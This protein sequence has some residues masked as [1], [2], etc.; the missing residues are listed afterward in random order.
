MRR[1]IYG[2]I[3]VSLILTSILSQTFNIPKTKAESKTWIVD[4][5]GPAD[6]HTIADAVDVADEGDT[7]LVAAGKYY[8]HDIYIGKNHI[9]ILGEDPDNTI[10]EARPGPGCVFYVYGDGVT[11]SGFTIQRNP[12]DYWKSVVGIHIYYADNCII[13]NNKIKGNGYGILL[14]A[15]KNT[16]ITGNYIENNGVAFAL[17]FRPDDSGNIFYNNIVSSNIYV[18]TF[19]QS[20]QGGSSN[21]I[22][23]HNNFLNYSKVVWLNTKGSTVLWDNGYPSGGNYWSNYA[24][25]DVDGDGIGDTP[26]VID[27]N[28]KDRYPLMRP[29][30]ATTANRYNVLH[31]SVFKQNELQKIIDSVGASGLFSITQVSVEDFNKG[32]PSDLSVYDALVFG[33]NDWGEVA[34]NRSRKY[35]RLA[36]LQN[37]VSNGGGI[38][39]THDTLEQWW[40]Y[41]SQIE[42]P[43][44]VDNYDISDK[45][46]ERVWYSSIKIVEDHAIL[47]HPYEIGNVGDTI[48]VQYTHTNGGRVKTAKTIIKSY[49]GKFESQATAANDF[50]LTINEYGKGRVAI[51]EIG[52]S[53]IREDKPTI[54]N[55]P[56][57][58]ESKILVNTLY[59]VSS[60]HVVP[61]SGYVLHVQSY[62][63]TGVEISYSGD[64]SGS[65]TTNFDIGPKEAPFTVTLKAPLIHGD[66]KFSH[67][68]L[69]G[70][71]MGQSNTL[72]VKVDDEKMERTAVAVYSKEVIKYTLHVKSEP[73]TGVSISYS[74]DYSGTGT[75]NFDVGPKEARFRVILT[76]PSMFQNYK[77]VYWHIP[78]LRLITVENPF[79]CYHLKA[80]TSFNELTVIAVYSKDTSVIDLKTVPIDYTGVITLT[81]RG[82]EEYAGVQELKFTV[83][84]KLSNLIAWF[85]ISRWDWHPDKPFSAPKEYPN[86]DFNIRISNSQGKEYS[87]KMNTSRG[88]DMIWIPIP[89]PLQ[90]TWTIKIIAF[91]EDSVSTKC[92][93]HLNI[94]EDKSSIVKPLTVIK[95]NTGKAEEKFGCSLWIEAHSKHE[96]VNPLMPSHKEPLAYFIS[97]TLHSDLGLEKN[98][99][100]ILVLGFDDVLGKMCDEQVLCIDRGKSEGYEEIVAVT[101]P[102]VQFAAKWSFKIVKILSQIVEY[103]A[104][105]IE[106]LED[107]HGLYVSEVFKPIIKEA[108]TFYEKLDENK[109]DLINFDIPASLKGWTVSDS[110][111]RFLTYCNLSLAPASD[112]KIFTCLALSHK[113]GEYYYVKPELL[114]FKI[115]GTSL[116]TA[117]YGNFESK[118]G[119]NMKV[120][121]KDILINES[122][123]LMNEQSSLHNLELT[124]SSNEVIDLGSVPFEYT[125][126]MKLKVGLGGGRIGDQE[127][128]FEVNQ[129]FENIIVKVNILTDGSIPDLDLVSVH[130][131]DKQEKITYVSKVFPR[132]KS[133]IAIA[134]PKPKNFGQ[135]WNI[136]IFAYAPI[137]TPSFKYS[138]KIEEDPNSIVK[139]LTL[140]N[141]ETKQPSVF[142][143]VLW[144]QSK[145]LKT[146]QPIH[147]LKL[148]A[149]GEVE[150]VISVQLPSSCWIIEDY[151]NILAFAYDDVLGEIKIDKTINREIG[152]EAGWKKADVTTDKYVQFAIKWGIAYPISK[153]PVIGTFI[154][155]VELLK[156]FF[157]LKIK[158]YYEQAVKKSY[159]LYKTSMDENQ[160]DIIN[161]FIPARLNWYDHAFMAK[162]VV[163]LKLS[164][165]ASLRIF[166]TL[167]AKYQD[168]IKT[169][170]YYIEPQ[171]F[172]FSTSGTKII[173]KENHHKLYLGLYDNKGS[174]VGFDPSVGRVKEE[175]EGA[176]YI[177]F[178]NGTTIIVLPPDYKDFQI[179][180]DASQAEEQQEHYD[181][182]II[183]ITQDGLEIENHFQGVINK[184]E[185]QKLKVNVSDSSINIEE[186]K[187]TI[188]WWVQHQLW[189]VAGVIGS[190]AI[191]TVSA[192]L[193]RRRKKQSNQPPNTTQ[194]CNNKNSVSHR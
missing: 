173:M 109:L 154:D 111:R 155:V 12:Y 95:L 101:D 118:T 182:T 159:N 116:D 44:G 63:I 189:I 43:A 96:K 128:S 89:E 168:P 30:I 97:V 25:C 78:E 46:R 66:H 60:A 58:K 81:E 175:I 24:G 193:I 29:Y 22:F 33:I 79:I 106:F 123:T 135:K 136:S 158:N 148:P 9:S 23:Y 127:L 161:F 93:Y 27:E 164:P 169:T 137:W 76:A 62:P 94:R 166:L 82:F 108:F 37:Y 147:P 74:G 64:Y 34:G 145:D 157:D 40:D 42:E 192:A 117:Y 48:S 26:Y 178:M 18:V 11:I 80:Y 100:N 115:A 152:Y 172:E 124:T 13:T 51:I 55:I 138:I 142:G 171:Y 150:Y 39:W 50:Y 87:V 194:K 130:V 151:P 28:N 144:I 156:D 90:G 153:I 160:F 57:E 141:A 143:T 181:L 183:H 119:T 91:T 73:I 98:F 6:F 129:D 21:N 56:S 122:C 180:V 121:S 114:E 105:L 4:D 176:C 15:T 139:S 126:T 38:V 77:F 107:L 120:S 165:T 52:H 19:D 88:F 134:I 86:I 170:Y 184:N 84:Q 167:G 110:V 1:E 99:P 132:D 3:L 16:T 163:P 190:A 41:G 36:E 54:V 71:N 112:L 47:H 53:T 72:T 70:V 177:D 8:E 113:S 45:N 68:L 32:N 17:E 131:Y 188:S 103:G 191:L 2:I 83:D 61:P 187:E 179:V 49:N 7:I 65:G 67:W 92:K 102:N 186:V 125:G 31:I 140:I 5:D 20:P 10:I 162:F 149:H 69:D 75:T 185:L 35:E 59:W 174:Y 85:S 104:D 146:N 14:H 133:E